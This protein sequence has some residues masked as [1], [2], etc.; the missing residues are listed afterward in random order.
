MYAPGSGD[1]LSLTPDTIEGDKIGV[2]IPLC[3][4]VPSGRGYVDHTCRLPAEARICRSEWWLSDD[5]MK[6]FPNLRHFPL[7]KYISMVC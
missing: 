4:Q 6:I 1:D 5:G 2:K 3:R 7:L